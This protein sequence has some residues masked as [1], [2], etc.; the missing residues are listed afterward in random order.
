MNSRTI[1]VVAV[2]FLSCFANHTIYVGTLVSKGARLGSNP[3]CFEGFFKEIAAQIAAEDVNSN[4]ELMPERKLVLDVRDLKRD[5]Y[6]TLQ[7][8]RDM[9]S[10]YTNSTI[11]DP[12]AA[13]VGTADDDLNELVQLTAER[14]VVPQTSFESHSTDL[15]NAKLYP[16][17][18]RLSA[19]QDLV[20]LSLLKLI[21]QYHWQRFNIIAAD[22]SDGSNAIEEVKNAI[23]LMPKEFQ[24]YVSI[25]TSTRYPAR[26]AL[27]LQDDELESVMN[28]LNTI[29]KTG[30]RIN[31]LFAN[32]VQAAAFLYT[33]STQGM[34]GE[35][36]IYLGTDW[37]SV[38][39]YA[40]LEKEY[41]ETVRNA[42]NGMVGISPF[43]GDLDWMVTEI[44]KYLK[45][46]PEV[47]E[48]AKAVCGKP[49][50]VKKELFPEYM[51]FAYDAVITVAMG[52]S[53]VL[54]SFPNAT[55]QSVPERELLYD[56]ILDVSFT[57]HSGNIHFK[58]KIGDR[59]PVKMEI[60]NIFDG[61]ITDIGDAEFTA[62][63]SRFTID[64]VPRWPGGSTAIPTDRDD[65]GGDHLSL[66]MA[67]TLLWMLVAFVFGA[68]LE[69]W[70]VQRLP[71]SGAVVLFGI[72]AG[73]LLRYTNSSITSSA[74]FNSSLFTLFLLPIIIFESG[75]NMKTKGIFF[76][77]IGTIL[78]YAV[79][80][81]LINIFL[82]GLM[83]AGL[84]NLHFFDPLSLSVTE[85]LIFGALI[86]ST[87]PVCTLGVFGALAVEPMLSMLIYG[88]S[89]IND[90]VSIVVYRTI[91]KFLLTPL[92]FAAIMNA[93]GTFLIMLFGS[94]IIG[95]AIALIACLILKYIKISSVVTETIIV[96][97]TAYSAFE[98]TEACE[99][100]G[101]TATLAC[102]VT[103][104]YF[105]LRNLSK[106]SREFAQN[107]VKVASSVAD[108]LIFFQ[109]GVNVF[110][111][112][113]LED[114]P[115]K[116]VL[117]MYAITTVVRFVTV[118]GLT[119]F[120]NKKRT[121]SK[122]SL[123]SQ[124]MMVH[125][126]LR[127][128]VS[129]SLALTFPSHNQT[130]V[131]RVTMWLIILTIFIQGCSTYDMLHLLKIPLH[132]NYDTEART[133]S[134]KKRSIMVDNGSFSA[135]VAGWVERKVIPFFTKSESDLQQ[136]LIDPDSLDNEFVTKESQMTPMSA[137]GFTPRHSP[138]SSMTRIVKGRDGKAVV[139]R[140]VDVE[141]DTLADEKDMFV[142]SDDEIDGDLHQA[143]ETNVDLAKMSIKSNLSMRSSK[144]SMGN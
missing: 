74:G 46:H 87:D 3:Y 119:Y 49:L 131:T 132:C 107:A 120:I 138:M 61:Q 82:I 59:F 96:F 60:V 72:V 122:I 8:T 12:M 34:T 136:P 71:E 43:V 116:L 38:L 78:I 50:E 63:G 57:G 4:P 104:N 100:S 130:E 95:A 62:K 108:T 36:W 35:G 89:V 65:E 139:N 1:L 10:Y 56:K 44:N 86:A 11:T 90:A 29:K 106:P 14:F 48:E 117:C 32:P 33:A 98:L 47:Q 93:C 26:M 24:D 2:L 105:S 113:S 144:R 125:S 67:M 66:Y 55:F 114:V 133:S 37:N 75:F 39:T 54:K 141:A 124:L 123:G 13:I 129:Y 68:L 70:E 99:L 17:F 142:L 53:E 41:R 21:D 137:P 9:L 69:H 64:K 91:S 121:R 83:M 18:L 31:I 16:Y 51:V 88:E 42:M 126:G 109:V 22:N 20:A 140:V 7:V 80:G 73:L 111:E 5:R 28:S 112:E 84:F 52:I 27:P 40:G 58:P 135:W 127:G 102:G 77:N 79:F 25:G 85:C 110:L 23:D 128:A 101:I 19:S 134:T 115:W 143:Q 97:L 76:K 45:A 118:F 30:N 6:E 94:T 103:M 81:T 92:S 15:S